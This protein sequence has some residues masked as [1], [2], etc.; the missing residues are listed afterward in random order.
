MQQFKEPIKEKKDDKTEDDVTDGDKIFDKMGRDLGASQN[1]I[2]E[3][4]NEQ[5]QKKEVCS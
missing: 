3:L 4:E 5:E 2:A 1:A